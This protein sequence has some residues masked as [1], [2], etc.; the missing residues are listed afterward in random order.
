MMALFALQDFGKRSHDAC[1]VARK[2]Y[3]VLVFES[4]SCRACFMNPGI[5]N[6]F[7]KFFQVDLTSG[8]YLMFVIEENKVF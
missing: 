2:V 1:T 8:R 5:V 6:T 4:N 3:A 7:E